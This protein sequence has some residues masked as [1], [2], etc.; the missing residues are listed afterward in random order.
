MKQVSLDLPSWG[1]KRKGA[2]RPPKGERAGVSHLRREQFPARHPVHVTMR[3]LPAVGFLRG[4]RR[5]R[6]IKDA[7]HEAQERFG[8]RVIHYSIQGNHLHLI[9]E[10][11]GV[12][13]LARGIQGLTIRIA[14]ALNRISRRAGKVFADRYHSHVLRSLREVARAV[15]YVLANALHHLREDVVPSGIDPCC[16]LA[17]GAPVLAPRTWLLRQPLRL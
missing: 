17:D 6:A 11:P 3:T 13:D 1:G 7:I 9:V 8:L 5:H 15:R 2:G 4:H 10:A 14:R 12:D 16:S